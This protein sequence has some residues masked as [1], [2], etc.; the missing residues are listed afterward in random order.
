MIISFYDKNFKALQNNSGLVVDNSNYSLIKRPVE[1]NDFS[2]VCEAFTED[3]QPTFLVVRDDKGSNELVYA[4]LAGIP[5]LNENNQTEINGTD[6]KSMLSSDIIVTATSY[7]TVNEYITYVFDQW[8]TQSNQ[9]SFDCELIFNENVGTIPITTLKQELEDVCEVVNAWE[10]I[11]PYLRFY[12]LYMDTALDI[13]NKKVKFIIGK[14]MLRN[15]NIKLWEY[16][17]K[18]YGK[19]V[20][21]TNESQGYYLPDDATDI[22][23]LQTG[24]K[25][26]LTSQNNITTTESERDIYP[27]KRK[28]VLSNESLA[29]AN[30]E[31]L[32][33]LLD[34]LYNENIEI[35]T[36]SI[37]PTFET[38][39]AI[40][41]KQGEEKY[42]DLPCGELR[43][44][45]TG[46]I[47]VQIG[48]RY[49]DINFI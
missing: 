4:S 16:G 32:E 28:V 24:Y 6:I 5:S 49:T 15:L 35:Q 22:S 7:S 11:Q 3:M 19:W 41:V 45:A 42:K 27:I 21:D 36:Q 31:A 46:L 23:S 29:E 43:Y 33:E 1:M 25:W 2:C 47:E 34:S 40:Y 38:N 17:I 39:F 30:E 14:T 8:N 26:I 37:S 20:A 48:Y 44:D 18:N 12:G 13:V 10:E 9:D